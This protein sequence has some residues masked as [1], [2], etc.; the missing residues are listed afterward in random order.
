[1]AKVAL[2]SNYINH[3]QLP[4][5]KQMVSLTNNNFNFV[6]QKA[7]SLKRIPLGYKDISNDYDFV[8]KTYES[9]QELDKAYKLANECDYVIFG[10]TKDDYFIQR[11]NENKITFEYSERLNKKKKSIYMYIKTYISFLIHRRKYKNN[12]LYLLCS[13]GYVANDFNMFNTYKGKTYKWGYFPEFIEYDIDKLIKAKQNNKLNILWTG[14]LIDWKHPE[15]VIE[16]AKR[17]KEDACNF[18]INII[19]SG[20]LEEIIKKDIIDSNLSNE[21]HMLGSMSPEEV[22]KHME[23]ANALL[24]TSD[25]GEGWG[26]VVNEGMNSGCVVLSSSTVGSSTFL[27]KHK[28]NGL[29]YRNDDFED[30]YQNMQ[31]LFNNDFRNNLGINAYNTIKSEWNAEVAATRF[32]KLAQCLDKGEDTPFTDGPCSKAIPIKDKDMYNYLVKE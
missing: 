1:M 25:T 23:L 31:L 20:E 3:H 8:V 4:F 22:R 12:K 6:S 15:L 30:L 11:L 9:K 19:G 26:V 17:L 10:A 2:F 18:E 13:G 5:C 14:R 7:I 29:I 27:I 28:H 24:I 21:V 32:L 16:L